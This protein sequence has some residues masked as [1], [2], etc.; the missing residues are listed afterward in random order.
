L[1]YIFHIILGV[2]IHSTVDE[3]DK[4]T[5]PVIGF[6]E[7]FE[8]KQV[9]DKWYEIFTGKFVDE[10]KESARVCLVCVCVYIY[11]RHILHYQTKKPLHNRF[12]FVV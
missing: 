3:F 2:Q 6:C 5:R 7:Q 8:E 9:G 10:V 4:A 1:L 11:M 12:W